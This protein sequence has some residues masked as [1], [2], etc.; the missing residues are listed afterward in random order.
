M[1]SDAVSTAVDGVQGYSTRRLGAC[2]PVTDRGL[3]A[4]VATP[5]TIHRPP[6]L[7]FARHRSR[8]APTPSPAP[9]PSPP[10]PTN[11]SLPDPPP[12]TARSPRRSERCPL[13][14]P[15]APSHAHAHAHALLARTIPPQCTIA[16]PSPTYPPSSRAASPPRRG[17]QPRTR[18][19]ASHH[20]RPRRLGRTMSTRPS[21]DMAYSLSPTRYAGRILSLGW[22]LGTLGAKRKEVTQ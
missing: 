6:T 21:N 13:P 2:V 12:S 17:P 15:V 10:A 7:P 22:K 9:S 5:G 20:R 14:A 18:A 1:G 4:L 16:P 19:Q 3:P 8:S 11:R